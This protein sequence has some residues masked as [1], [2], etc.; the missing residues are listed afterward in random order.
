[1]LKL[2]EA[3]FGLLASALFLMLCACSLAVDEAEN[4]EGEEGAEE[5]EIHFVGRFETDLKRL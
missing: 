4:G 5:G 1:M 2:A 3:S